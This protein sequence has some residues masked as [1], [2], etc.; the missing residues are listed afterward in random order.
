MDAVAGEFLLE[1]SVLVTQIGVHVN[2]ENA[3]PVGQG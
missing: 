2:I 3:A 1:I